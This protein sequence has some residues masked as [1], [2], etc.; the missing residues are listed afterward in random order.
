MASYDSD[1]SDDENY[2]ETTVLLGYASKDPTDDT[3]SQL[4][5][6][7]VGGRDMP[8]VRIPLNIL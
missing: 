4:G 3:V 7:P 5:G 2:T 1:S 8:F 6:Y